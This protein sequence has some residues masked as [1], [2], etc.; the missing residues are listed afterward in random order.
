MNSFMRNLLTPQ[1][2]PQTGQ[3]T[4]DQSI[5]NGIQQ[6]QQ[7]VAQQQ[8]NQVAQNIGYN[9]LANSLALQRMIAAQKQ[10]YAD[11]M[12]AGDQTGMDRAA[13]MT[14]VLR[15]RGTKDNYDMSGFGA[16]N[17]LDEA[18]ANLEYNQNIVLNKSL[19]DNRDSGS[20]YT[21]RYDY[22]KQQGMNDYSADHYAYQ[23]AKSFQGNRVNELSNM[24][25]TVGIDPRGHLNK[26]GAQ[27]MNMMY[28]E[29]PE[30]INYLVDQIPSLKDEWA[31]QTQE[32]AKENQL[33]REMAAAGYKNDLSKDFLGAQTEAQMSLQNNATSNDIAKMGANFAGQKDL[34]SFTGGAQQATPMTKAEQKALAPIADAVGSVSKNSSYE[35][36]EELADQIISQEAQISGNSTQSKQAFW[37][38]YHRVFGYMIEKAAAEGNKKLLEEYFMSLYNDNEGDENLTGRKWLENNIPKD[39]LKSYLK[40]LGLKAEA[41]KAE[42][43]SSS[44]ATSQPEQQGPSNFARVYNQYAM[45]GGSDVGAK[46]NK[47]FLGSGP[48][49]KK[50]GY[51]QNIAKDIAPKRSAIIE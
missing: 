5:N 6:E 33:G 37:D 47:G 25:F 15:D 28:Q 19:G 4:V 51:N 48:V 29:K 46:F 38:A 3:Q 32:L 42:E 27:I 41:R 22:Y 13:N 14:R 20:Y 43:P 23:D 1:V 50:G 39:A 45:G 2:Q 11:A 24:L 18:L 16:D 36:L 7:Q 49:S 21:D 9:Q 40:E 12:A 31:F 44:E 34:I 26:R 30:S 17:T 8:M 35:E 10:N